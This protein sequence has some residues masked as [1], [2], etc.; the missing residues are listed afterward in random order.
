MPLERTDHPPRGPQRGLG[1]KGEVARHGTSVGLWERCNL[2]RVGGER[3][4]VGV[5]LLGAGGHGGGV[6]HELARPLGVGG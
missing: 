3:V 1:D 5:P 6:D 4:A 2:A